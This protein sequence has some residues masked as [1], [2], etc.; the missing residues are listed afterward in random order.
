MTNFIQFH[1]GLRRL[2]STDPNMTS[3]LSLNGA[4]SRDFHV[5]NFKLLHYNESCSEYGLVLPTQHLSPS[6]E[7][8][9]SSLLGNFCSPKVCGRGGTIHW[10]PCSPKSKNG[11]GT[12]ARA[13]G[14]SPWDLQEQRSAG[15]P[16]ALCGSVYLVWSN[17]ISL[18]SLSYLIPFR[19]FPLTQVGRISF[20]ACF[21]ERCLW[22]MYVVYLQ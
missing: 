5:L 13:A 19:T 16:S 3:W 17:R 12:Q 10:V 2:E 8:L 21:K 1:A 22:N 9:P 14:L 7:S 20:F 18:H 4:I 11:C 6:R 15:A